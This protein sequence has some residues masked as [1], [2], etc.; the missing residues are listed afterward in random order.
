MGAPG[1]LPLRQAVKQQQGG[2]SVSSQPKEA[3]AAAKYFKV[4]YIKQVLTGS[5]SLA[6]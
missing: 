6:R 5:L 2:T 1:L 3:P 4:L